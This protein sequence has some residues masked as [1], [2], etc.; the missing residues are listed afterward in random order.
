MTKKKFFFEKISQYHYYILFVLLLITAVCTAFVEIHKIKQE[1]KDFESMY[2]PR[3]YQYV[4]KTAALFLC[5][6][7]GKWL[8]HIPDSTTGTFVE[9]KAN[10]LYVEWI[11]TGR[12]DFIG[13]SL[14]PKLKSLGV[15]LDIKA[16][17]TTYRYGEYS[18]TFPSGALREMIILQAVEKV[19]KEYDKMID[20][21]RDAYSKKYLGGDKRETSAWMYHIFN[22]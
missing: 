16:D 10:T 6:K 17:S 19:G 11:E 18:A 12:K 3:P 7:D 1:E 20:A 13:Y 9:L 15:T 2:E 14:S 21:R 5:N 22:K 8:S 4:T